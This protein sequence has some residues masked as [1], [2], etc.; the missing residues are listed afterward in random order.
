MAL[1]RGLRGEIATT[2]NNIIYPLY[3]SNRI[4]PRDHVLIEKGGGGFLAYD[5]YEDIARDPHAF[6]VLQKRLMAVVSRDWEIL[7]ASEKRQDKKVAEFVTEVLEQLGTGLPVRDKTETTINT[8]GNFDQIC[9]ELM[10]AILYGFA[11]SEILWEQRDG[12]VIPEYVIAKDIRRFCFTIADRGGYNLRLVT[13]DDSHEGMPL[14]HG[15]FIVHRYNALGLHDDPY[16]LGLGARLFFPRWF[17]SNAVKSWLIFADKLGMPTLMGR[18]PRTASNS[19]K[20]TLLD[21]LDAIATDSGVAIPETMQIEFLE[22]QRGSTVATY[23]GLVDFCNNEISKVVLGETGSTD[24]QG[25]GGSRARDQV[26]NEIRIEIAKGDADLLS[27]TL[28]NTLIRWLVEYNFPAGTK[29]PSLVRLFPELDEKEDLGARA[30][31]DSTIVAMSER[32]LTEKYLVETYGVEF[33]EQKQDGL[34]ALFGGAGGDAAEPQTEAPAPEEPA[35]V[36][37][38]TAPPEEPEQPVE[39]PAPIDLAELEAAE[40]VLAELREG[41]P[42]ELIPSPVELEEPQDEE[43]AAAEAILSRMAAGDIQNFDEL[44]L[45]PEAP[46]L[47]AARAAL[48]RILSGDI[49]N[50]EKVEYLEDE[51]ELEWAEEVL[52]RILAGDIQNYD[53][54]ELIPAELSFEER[55]EQYLEF[56]EFEEVLEFAATSKPRKKPNCNPS[57]SQHC[58]GKDGGPGACVSKNKQ[59]RNKPVGSEKVAAEFNVKAVK[60]KSNPS[61]EFKPKKPRS[62]K[63]KLQEKTAAGD[64]R[65]HLMD[66]REKTRGYTLA[67][68]KRMAA[69][70]LKH[71]ESPDDN[72]LLSKVLVAQDKF[73][74]ARDRFNAKA[75]QFVGA[76]IGGIREALKASNA[77]STKKH[78][79]PKR[80]MLKSFEFEGIRYHF[81]EQSADSINATQRLIRDLASRGKLPEALAKHTRD[82]Y[83]SSQKHGDEA[84]WAEKYNRPNLSIAATGGNREAVFYNGEI[85]NL[86]PRSSLAHEMGHNLAQVVYGGFTP[87]STS[88]FARASTQH[89]APSDYAKVGLNE[90][91]AESVKYYVVDPGYLKVN[92]PPRYNVI[93]RLME[94]PGYAG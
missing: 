41:L 17:K 60:E 13:W 55:V 66:L 88:D 85:P 23:E 84:Y 61:A 16:G 59:C 89:P 86:T 82:V 9:F 73:Y 47:G 29:V 72:A 53:E 22:A 26:G 25:S 44:E 81:N 49:Q 8:G 48:E 37:E 15:K 7:P 63:A 19:E 31:R 74:K 28:N 56:D 1:R 57:V 10:S 80:E 76:Y 64:L 14:S 46:E 39:E 5:I 2:R 27:S 33:E 3:S 91:F 68:E 94:E 12:K 87:P 69:L 58:V 51:P 20:E 42:V 43:L 11:V 32:K 92:A 24:Q 40:A 36:E 79:M 45:I 62:S 71:Y 78:S 93:K 77:I 21:T 70:A 34:E 4:D 75:D 35:P 30:Q 18:Y 83:I 50:F 6:A 52:G 67:D 65:G 90:D 54:L 38:E